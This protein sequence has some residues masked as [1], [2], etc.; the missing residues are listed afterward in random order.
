LTLIDSPAA[1]GSSARQRLSCLQASCRTQRP[2]GWISPVSSATGTNSLGMTSVPS[3][4]RQRSSA[5]TPTIWPLCSSMMG[6]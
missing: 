2:I 6:W 4:R 1:W 5:S 3:G